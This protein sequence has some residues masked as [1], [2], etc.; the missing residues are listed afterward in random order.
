MQSMIET[1]NGCSEDFVDLSMY[2][3][4][5]LPQTEALVDRQLWRLPACY[6]SE[7]SSECNAVSCQSK[8]SS[9]SML[10]AVSRCWVCCC[11]SQEAAWNSVET[12]S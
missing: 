5:S 6:S 7:L 12:A 1:R 4:L 9:I 10:E 3:L 8:A 2:D 11:H